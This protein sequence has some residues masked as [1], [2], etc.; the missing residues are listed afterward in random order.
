MLL[1]FEQKAHNP[2]RVP[3]APSAAQDLGRQE[4]PVSGFRRWDRKRQK[5]LW[6]SR[7]NPDSSQALSRDRAHLSDVEGRYSFPIPRDVQAAGPQT[8][9]G[10]PHNSA[11]GR[12]SN[13]MATSGRGKP[14]QIAR[15][16]RGVS[17]RR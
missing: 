17:A 11:C 9:Q 3:S 8:Q 7:F 5:L 15:D 1:E 2:D 14:R 13:P 10:E 6:V 12:P 4:H 16:Q